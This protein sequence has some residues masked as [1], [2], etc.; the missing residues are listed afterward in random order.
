M[1]NL[2]LQ[3]LLCIL[4][5]NSFYRIRIGKNFKEPDNIITV[6]GLNAFNSVEEYLDYTISLLYLNTTTNPHSYD[7]QVYKE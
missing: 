6:N 3:A 2:K 7:I 1:N 4:P 5:V